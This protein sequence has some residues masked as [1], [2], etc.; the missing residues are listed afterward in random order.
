M[1]NMFYFEQLSVSDK[2]SEKEK[3]FRI[4]NNATSRTFLRKEH[5]M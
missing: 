3:Y 5:E 1:S 2:I 4:A